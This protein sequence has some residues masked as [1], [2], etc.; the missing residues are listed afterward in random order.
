MG[1]ATTFLFREEK[2]TYDLRS[3]YKMVLD[4]AEICTIRTIDK[5]GVLAMTL[6]KSNLDPK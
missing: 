2:Y 3:N 1:T 5:V 6:N 4:P